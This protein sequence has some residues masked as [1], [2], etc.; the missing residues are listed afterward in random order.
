MS[1]TG[2]ALLVVVALML[3]GCSETTEPSTTPT[4]SSVGAPP[5]PPRPSTVPSSPERAQPRLASDPAQL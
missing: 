3:A 4:Q 1:P 5:A 2:A